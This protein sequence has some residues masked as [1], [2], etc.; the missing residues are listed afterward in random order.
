MCIL[1][2]LQ[3][4]LLF[5]TN[6]TILQTQPEYNINTLEKNQFGSLVSA[7]VPVWY[8]CYQF[9]ILRNLNHYCKCYIITV[10]CHI[11]NN[12]IILTCPLRVKFILLIYK[13]VA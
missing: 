12:T 5:Q 11:G 6:L 3:I 7:L 10:H 9:R 13:S 2:L 1:T 8:T 4:L